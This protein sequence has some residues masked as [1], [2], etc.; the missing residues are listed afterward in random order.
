MRRPAAWAGGIV[1]TAAVAVFGFAP[2]PLSAKRVAD[3]LNASTG[4]SAPLRW[5]APDAAAFRALP[6]PSLSIVGLRLDDALGANLISAPEARLDLSP[7]QLVKGRFAPVRAPLVT[8]I[9]TLDLDRPPCAG[10]RDPG[11]GRPPGAL[12]PLGGPEPDQ[13]RA[14]RRQPAAVGS[15]P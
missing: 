14:A 8:P 1:V 10:P 5:G 3:G 11:G 12:A 9:V 7:G 6:W 15:T 13:R 2:W 4:A